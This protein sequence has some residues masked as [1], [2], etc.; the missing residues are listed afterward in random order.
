[1]KYNMLDVEKIK[2][3][4]CSNMYKKRK[5][6]MMLMRMKKI[7]AAGH[8]CLDV[9]PIFPQEKVE[10]IDDILKPGRLIN[11]ENVSISTGGSVANTGLALKIL[12][13]DVSLMGKIGNDDFGKLILNILEQHQAAE[14]MLV[15]KGER[16]S[17][18]VVLAI[19]G[20]D[21]I[22]LHDPGANDTF[23]AEDVPEDV[24]K[25]AALF[26]LGYPPLMKQ[27]YRENGSEL[28][29]VMRRAKECG[30]AT[31]LDFTS[32]D[33][34]A[35]VGKVDWY[36]LLKEVIPYVDFFVPS[37]EEL[38]YML[39]KERFY[40][41]QERAAGKDITEV[42]NIEQDVK[43]L[44]DICMKLGAKVLLI[45][46]GAKGMYYRTADSETLKQI[47]AK[48]ELDIAKWADR[49][50]FEKSF[51]PE[52][53]ASGTGAGDTSIAAFLKA[54]IDGNT[55]EESV[56]LAAATGACC[57][58]S[59]DALGGLKSFDELRSKIAAGWEKNEV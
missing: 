58:A 48:A 26:H 47:G 36:I 24:L 4:N 37:V 22:F 59:Y 34:G 43:P 2:L 54:M 20:I 56:Q 16:T 30:V 44:A 28:K 29:K 33:E 45:K 40:R 31:S 51:K 11:M 46:C 52:R 42:L 32:I 9:T 53:I 3:T 6:M 23:C 38:C 55:I 8:I 14:G 13:A 39:D 1:M 50:G 25:E 57:V 15:C 17:Y 19:P 5:G 27:M 12:G 18:S 35:E 49:D 21:R 7:I 41:W 10:R